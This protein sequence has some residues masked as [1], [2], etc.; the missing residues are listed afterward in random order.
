MLIETDTHTHTVSSGHAYSTL[1]ENARAAKAAGIRLMAMTDHAPTMP[2][3]PHIWHFG[4]LKVVPRQIEGVG[5]LRG[6]EANICDE[7]GHIDIPDD[8]LNM[9]D[10]VIGSFHEPVFAPSNSAVHT[11]TLERVIASGKVDIIGHPGN[12][13]FPIDINA[14]VQAA[15][16]HQVLIEL[17]NSS[18]I[19]SRR[20][21]ESNCTAIAEAARDF[22]AYITLGS[23]SHICYTVG[24]FKECLAILEHVGFPPERLVSTKAEKLLKFLSKRGKTHLSEFNF[25]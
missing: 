17:N 2:G 5:I 22:G 8:Y 7:Q 12:P 9:L 3:A 21:S 11:Q 24:Q 23:D 20:G 13:N 15:A 16:Q 4:N 14:V 25:L 18:F 19:S 6:V 1:Q 10:I